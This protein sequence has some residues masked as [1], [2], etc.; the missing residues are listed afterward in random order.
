MIS[1]QKQQSMAPSS[2][3]MA[4]TRRPEATSTWCLRPLLHRPGLL[5]RLWLLHCQ[6]VWTKYGRGPVRAINEEA[7]APVLS[8]HRAAATGFAKGAATY[9][10]GRPDYPPEV[11][12]WLRGDLSLRKGK[13]VLD[14]GAGTGK[15]IPS[16][17]AT[18]A[19]I[20]A[21]EPV[22][23]MLA[24]LVERN[25]GITAKEGSAEH[26]PLA[27]NSVDAVVCAQSFHWFARRE[28]LAEIHRVLKPGGVLGLIW[29]VRNE[30]VGWVAALTEIMRPY[31]GNTPRHHTQK[32]RQLFPAE[33]FGP[34]RERRFPNA[35]P[36]T[37]NR[38]SSIAC[39][40]PVSSPRSRPS[41]RT[42]SSRKCETDRVVARSCR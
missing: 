11:E 20:I 13:T 41:S 2:Q 32:W 38:S 22:P 40:P 34:L 31:E 36:A 35:T 9:V 19:A 18:D 10:K 30:S 27:G 29:N 21:V 6:A 4:R 14:L 39:S 3:S 33:G 12:D 1:L 26:I 17:R 5:R 25:P 42:A 24:Q 23:A 8:I 16:L 7:A 15:F 28:A 37:P